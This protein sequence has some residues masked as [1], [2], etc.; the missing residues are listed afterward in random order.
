MNKIDLVPTGVSINL[1]L[2]E[3]KV[4][5]RVLEV[6]KSWEVIDCRGGMLSSDEADFVEELWEKLK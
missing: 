3:E 1:T 5:I 6:L 2:W 4:L